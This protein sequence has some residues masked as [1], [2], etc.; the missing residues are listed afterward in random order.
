MEINPSS[1]LVHFVLIICAKLC[2]VLRANNLSL[3]TNH[4]TGRNIENVVAQYLNNSYIRLLIRELKNSIMIQLITRTGFIVYEMQ[5]RTN[6][7]SIYENSK[8]TGEIVILAP[9]RGRRVF[10]TLC[11]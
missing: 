9:N 11:I 8:S 3:P 5:K 4:L 7:S 1:N 6:I 10:R 2:Y